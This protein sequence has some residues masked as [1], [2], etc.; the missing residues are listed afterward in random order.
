MHNYSGPDWEE[1]VTQRI[2]DS[3][4]STFVLIDDP[5]NI[6]NGEVLSHLNEKESK[7]VSIADPMVLRF[8]FEDQIRQNRFD[9]SERIIFIIRFSFSQVPLDIRNNADILELSLK[10]FFPKLSYSI[11]RDLPVSWHSTIYKNQSERLSSRQSQDDIGTATF[12]IRECLGLDYDPTPS[13]SNILSLLADVALHKL[14]IPPSLRAFLISQPCDPILSFLYQFLDTPAKSIQF[15]QKTW[16]HYIDYKLNKGEG[17]AESLSEDI[18]QSIIY[19]DRDRE[20]QTKVTALIAENIL[21]PAN[22]VENPS[23]PS[24]MHLGVHYFEDSSKAIKET[25]EHL[26]HIMP[27]DY[28]RF[29]D[30]S[31]FAFQWADW[32]VDYDKVEQGNSEI[33]KA[34]KEFI[35]HLDRNYS[36]WLES[37][38][39]SLL[40]QP[41]LPYP[42]CVHHILHQLFSTFKPTSTH[43]LALIVVDGMAIQDWLVIQSEWVSVEI[44]WEIETKG[45]LALVPSLTSV[46]RQALL[47]GKLPRYFEK[48]WLNTNSEEMLWRLF[49]E[50]Q[51]LNP[52]SIVYHRGLGVTQSHDSMLETSLEES[53]TRP[54]ISVAA[55]IVNT[56]DNLVHTSVLGQHDL[57]SRVSIWTREKRYLQGLV[58]RLLDQFDTVV[59]TSDHGHIAGTGIGDLSL[60]SIAEE[61]ALRTRIFKGQVFEDLVRELPEIFLW[62]NTG[63]PEDA[64]IILPK[65]RGMFAK[66]DYAGIS[67]GG[68]C[69]EETIVPYVTIKR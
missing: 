33:Q 63:L 17:V 55:L 41:Y 8:E 45:V 47:S 48:N 42:T 51:G 5:D 25:L 7:V 46:S 66:K 57:F 40:M 39:P 30:W 50:E 56:I 6:I 13:F 49:W 10:Q 1:V 21:S 64:T 32:L 15:L 61:R 60:S 52:E 22:I 34:R 19:L 69:L 31:D 54:H 16:D 14:E 3:S 23:I 24:W 12:I 35:N 9:P 29:D 20:F 27:G 26:S 62:Q 4:K 65:G 11:I 44:P 59:I 58:S 53:L 68:S 36:S 37:H 38:Y 67:H 43:P 18:T 28:A 2:I